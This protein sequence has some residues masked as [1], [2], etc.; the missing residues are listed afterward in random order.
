[1]RLRRLSQALVAGTAVVVLANAG[2]AALLVL[3]PVPAQ[4]APAI[5]SAWRKGVLLQRKITDAEPRAAFAAEMAT[6]GTTLIVERPTY[7]GRVLTLTQALFALSVLPGRDGVRA[8]LGGRD[9]WL[10]PH[11]LAQ[12]HLYSGDPPARWFGPVPGIDA[13]GVLARLGAEL[14]CS[15]D[16]LLKNGR[17]RRFTAT[18]TQIEDLPEEQDPIKLARRTNTAT[19]GRLTIAVEDAAH[20]LEARVTPDGHYADLVPG[21]GWRYDWLAHAA[22][23]VFL[24]EAGSHFESVHIKGAA[25]LAA[26]LMQNKVTARCGPDPCVGEGDRVDIATSALALRAYAD[27]AHQKVGAIFVQPTN[28]LASFLRAMQR[29][30]GGFHAAYDRRQQRP[31]DE[32]RGDFDGEAVVALAR[33]HLVT[34]NPADLEA[35]SLGLDHL[36][37]RPGFIGARDYLDADYHICDA[38]S[39]LWQRYPNQSALDY[40][41][42][43]SEWASLMQLDSHGPIPAFGG[44]YRRDAGWV[45]DLPSTAARIEGTIATLAA[46]LRAGVSSDKVKELDRRATG[47]LELLLREQLPGWRAYLMPNAESSLGGFARTPFDTEPRSDFT[48]ASGSAILRCLKVL[49]SRGMPT[50][51]RFRRDSNRINIPEN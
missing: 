4:G 6:P 28:D 1:V 19:G 34:K 32:E 2:L 31:V 29:P 50:P 51:K 45:P 49:E 24:A 5:V 35:A 3:R 17:L 20:F 30:D 27:L 21:P 38:A 18:W 23:T 33:A 7:E 26:W 22:T 11:D 41:F 44:G 25:R 39:D 10:T 14:G 40:C 9:A 16:Y 12:A 48:A 46:A 47:G 8:T 37:R 43:W 36:I 15:G 42:V 13:D